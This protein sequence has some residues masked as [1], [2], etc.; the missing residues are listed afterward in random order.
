MKQIESFFWGIIA[1]LGALVVELIVFMLFSA[2]SNQIAN[3]SFS[4]L[5]SIPQFVIAMVLVEEILKYTVI[6]TRIDILSMR[7]SYLANSLLV[8]LGFFSIELG[9][10]LITGAV[11]QISILGE[12]ALVHIG[13]AGLIGYIVATKNPKK[14]ST[15]IHAKL[16]TI[17]FHGAYN[18]LII[19]RTFIL[20]YA[21]FA[22]LVVLIFINLINL[23]RIN[24]KLAQ[25]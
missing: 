8:G 18:L 19:K 6:S 15:F 23:A 9:L 10:I 14:I 24:R 25:D 5:F 7:R 2:S 17:F 21:V 1:A 13:T 20:N 11:P 16:L 3:L 4:Q 12:I 22:L